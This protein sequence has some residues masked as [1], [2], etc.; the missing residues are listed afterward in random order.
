MN[1]YLV[2]FVFVGLM[3][4]VTVG[5]GGMSSINPGGAGGAGGV[6]ATAATGLP[7]DVQALVASR[8]DGCHG[9]TP[10]SGAPMSLVTYADLTAPSLADPTMTN[11]RRALVRVVNP[12]APMPPAPATMLTTTEVATLQSWVDAGYPMGSCA[13]AGDP[14]SVAPT[15]TT[16]ITWTRGNRGSDL[17]NPGLACISCHA[18][19]TQAPVLTIAGTVYP[20]AHE[21]DLCNGATPATYA[22]AAVVIVGAN[23]QTITLTP[24]AAGNFLYQGTV[25]VPFRVKL[26][27]MG[28]ER[29]MTNSQT[30]G[31]CNSCHTQNG[32]NG[33]PGR[34]LLP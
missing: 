27:Y 15:C 10:S 30:S 2:A 16:G 12:S 13:A 9:T 31:D 18:T 22:G 28:R 33:A 20:S 11:A 3:S 7:C 34:I 25:A 8:C 32:A 26:T 6:G 21:P 1:K 14:F 5:C 23:Q 19:M 29:I 17:M 24:N 4:A